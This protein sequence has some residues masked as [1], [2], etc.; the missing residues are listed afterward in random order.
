MTDM[1]GMHWTINLFLKNLVDIAETE[2]RENNLFN[3]FM[4][5]TP[6]LTEDLKKPFKLEGIQRIDETPVH[7]AVR[8]A[9]VN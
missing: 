2:E 7:K 3:F 1:C 6:K 5:V 4:K 9:F 8:E